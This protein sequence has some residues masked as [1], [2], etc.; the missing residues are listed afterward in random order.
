MRR[1]L[2][3]NVD[4]FEPKD[5]EQISELHA[6]K[7]SYGERYS[8]VCR[9]EYEYEYTRFYIQHR[10]LSPLLKLNVATVIY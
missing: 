5:L 6:G 2:K 3:E 1:R 7:I 8:R 10:H 9:S 4:E